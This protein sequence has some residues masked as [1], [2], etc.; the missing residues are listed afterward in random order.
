M[1]RGPRLRR[2]YGEHNS[3]DEHRPVHQTSEHNQTAEADAGLPNDEQSLD[4]VIKSISSIQTVQSKM[5]QMM[6]LRSEQRMCQLQIDLERAKRFEREGEE[7]L[8]RAGM[9]PSLLATMKKDVTET[10]G[11]WEKAV[12]VMK[13]ENCELK[14]KLTL[15]TK[16][17]I[18][19]LAV[20]LGSA[21]C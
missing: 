14:V 19:N 8:S 2:S 1:R 7:V 20:I 4:E 15:A 21:Q 12:G 18:T 17:P 9:D 3:R 5:V 6:S 11:L 10:M 16:A 13:S